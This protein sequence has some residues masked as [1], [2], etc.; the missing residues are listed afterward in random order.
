VQRVNP[1]RTPQVVGGLLDV[2]CE[3]TFKSLPTS[4]IGEVKRHSPLKII[5][6]WVEATGL[7]D[8]GCYNGLAKIL[9]DSYSNPQAF[10]ADNSAS[11]ASGDGF[12]RL[13]MVLALRTPGLRKVLRAARS[14]L[15][16][17]CLRKR[18]R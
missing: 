7:Q 3:Q 18:L 15:G 13:R 4:V 9:V 6:P 11:L 16:L 10:P 17:Y 2:D 14:V 5:P 1:A 12:G 8:P